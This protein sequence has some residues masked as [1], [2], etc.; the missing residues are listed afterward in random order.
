MGSPASCGTRAKAASAILEMNGSTAR[1]DWFLSQLLRNRRRPSAE[2]GLPFSYW[3]EAVDLYLASPIECGMQVYFAGRTDR[4]LVK[5]G[6]ATDLRDRLRKLRKQAGERI[7]FLAITTGGRHLE[8]LYHQLFEK[9]RASL[10]WFRRSDRVE[11]EIA[12]L[13][14]GAAHA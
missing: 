11:A 3:R 14:G 10:E 6:M 5:I 13:T 1:K 9:E 2:E 12:R 8:Y 4:G 7:E